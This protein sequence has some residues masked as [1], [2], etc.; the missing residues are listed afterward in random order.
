[1]IFRI[2][3]VLGFYENSVINQKLNGHMLLHFRFY[4]EEVDISFNVLECH[5]N[6]TI[7]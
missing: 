6:F 7:F 5:I 4:H 1:M 2:F 3:Q